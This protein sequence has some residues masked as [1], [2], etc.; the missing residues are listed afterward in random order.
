[1]LAM[2]TILAVASGS[3]AYVGLDIAMVD[4]VLFL[5]SC[6]LQNWHAYD[7]HSR[8]KWACFNNLQT[9]L[10]NIPTILSAMPFDEG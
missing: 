10:F 4:Q 7:H 3:T 9:V 6:D 8:S 1:M 5:S 2:N